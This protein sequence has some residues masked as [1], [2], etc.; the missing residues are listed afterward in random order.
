M[1]KFTVVAFRYDNKNSVVYETTES[2]L[3]VCGL[4]QRALCTEKADVISIRKVYDKNP[5]VPENVFSEILPEE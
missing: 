2:V 3:R 4:V 1:T 5:I